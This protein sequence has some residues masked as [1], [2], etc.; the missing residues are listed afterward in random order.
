MKLASLSLFVA[1]LFTSVI[2]CA[3]PKVFHDH[4]AVSAPA[5][6]K[7]LAWSKV[8]G[9]QDLQVVKDGSGPSFYIVEPTSM[10]DGGTV[11]IILGTDLLHQ[12]TVQ[13]WDHDFNETKIMGHTCFGGYAYSDFD[14]G[15]YNSTLYL[16]K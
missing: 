8:T 6:T 4:V 15:Y 16:K 12:C 11:S 5:G 7:F 14:P 3:A 9:P 2:C 10:Q 1:C 13:I